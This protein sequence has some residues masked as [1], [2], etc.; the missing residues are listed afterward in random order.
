M[1]PSVFAANWYVDNAVATSGNGQSWGT[2][3][4]NFANINWNSVQPGD[5]VYIS[6]GSVSKTYYETL[7]LGKSGTA[8][9]YITIARAVDA[10]HNGRVIIDAGG[11]RARAVDIVNRN[12][13]KIKGFEMTNN[14][15]GELGMVMLDGGSNIII[16]SVRITEF[17][18]QGGVFSEGT[19][20]FTVSN[21][22]IGSL[23]TMNEQTDCIYVQRS[24]NFIIENN[25]LIQKN[26]W[27]SGST[28]TMQFYDLSGGYVI[29]RNNYMRVENQHGDQGIIGEQATSA[30]SLEILNNVVYEVNPSNSAYHGNTIVIKDTFAGPIKIYG[31]TLYGVDYIETLNV[32]TRANVE[33]KNNIIINTG[34][35]GIALSGSGSNFDYNMYY[36]PNGASIGGTRKPHEL[37]T[38]NPGFVNLANHDFR[39]TSSSPAIDAGT[40]LGSPYN[41]DNTYLARPQGA[42]WDM[43]AYE[44]ASGSSSCTNGQTQS[45]N[46][47]QSGICSA[48]T[49]TCSNNNWGAC[50]RNNNPT[51]EIC[52]NG[53]DED[54]TGADLPCSVPVLDVNGDG[55]VSLGEISS[56]VSAWLQGQITLGQVSSGVSQWLA[57]CQPTNVCTAGQTQSCTTGQQGICSAGTQTCSNNAWGTCVRNNNPS[58]E[59]CTD[60]LDN[61]C[62]GATDCLDSN[63]FSD[64]ACATPV[65]GDASCNGQETCSTCSQDCGACPAGNLWYVDNAVATSGNGQSW[66]T[67]WK[68]FNNIQWSSIQP[69]DT[70]YIS[71]GTTSKVYSGTLTPGKSGTVG[72]YITIARGIDAAHNGRVIIDGNNGAVDSGVYI[73]DGQDYLYI[74]GLDIRRTQRGVYISC[75]G[76]VV[77]NIVIDSMTIYEFYD[78]AGVFASGQCGGSP[79]NVINIVVKN[80]NITSTFVDTPGQTD[81]I[82]IA[83]A[84]NITIENNTLEQRNK[85]V[86]GSTDNLQFYNVEGNLIVRNNY[87]LQHGTHGDQCMILGIKGA[88]TVLYVYN[89]VALHLGDGNLFMVRSYDSTNPM[90]YI[91]ENTF[92]A[93]PQGYYYM[94][95]VVMEKRGTLKNNIIAWICDACNGG[96]NMNA[97]GPAAQMYVA[98]VL[99]NVYYSEYQGT[100]VP[101]TFGAYNGGVWHGTGGQIISETSV[102]WNDWLSMGGNGWNA[103]PNFVNLNNRN[104]KV[105]SGSVAIDNGLALGALYNKDFLGV[106]RP[107]GAGWDIGAYER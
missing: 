3:W 70:I 25:T 4:K 104:F 34:S 23:Y 45:C 66:G 77:N 79:L 73:N 61:D 86:E 46:T 55:C 42:G 53:I 92:V 17:R 97:N 11:T 93:V 24:K 59:S 14:A 102:P 16:D 2:A 44:Y 40:S 52:G 89:N 31:N 5:I 38:T 99:N 69:G 33:V 56:Y 67:A 7:T 65:C 21:S 29:I 72:N 22:Y 54:C 64:S 28:D 9:N 1:L 103:N 96:G 84:T 85:H 8:G 80:S 26:N 10:N 41:I 51:T 105:Q 107:Q 76:G 39:L 91:Y 15:A 30:T 94:H 101:T 20:G 106:S 88:S 71:G 95:T 32:P 81:N 37:V 98:D 75:D 19:D 47:G 27:V 82:Y 74:K 62:D 100:A 12:Y 58:T 68:N 50:V 78:H 90:S 87:M 18:G 35:N 57:G 48:G 36:A 49:Q 60:N 13:I 83:Q 6:G 43:G 63:C